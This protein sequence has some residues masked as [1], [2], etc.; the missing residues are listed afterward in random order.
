MWFINSANPMQHSK[1]LVRTKRYFACIRRKIW[2]GFVLP[3]SFGLIR[4]TYSTCPTLCWCFLFL[5]RSADAWTLIESIP[6][7]NKT[8]NS[9]LSLVSIKVALRPVQFHIEMQINTH[10]YTLHININNEIWYRCF[11]KKRKEKRM[12]YHIHTHTRTH[13]ETVH[14]QR[15]WW[16]D[17]IGKMRSEKI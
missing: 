12:L 16:W 13:N 6:K 5:F 9:V 11:R 3:H 15:W 1:S 14:N 8:K 4:F 7:S 2:F 10:R 17:A